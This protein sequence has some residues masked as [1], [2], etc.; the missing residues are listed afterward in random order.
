MCLYKSSGGGILESLLDSRFNGIPD[1]EFVEIFGKTVKINQVKWI[2]FILW[3]Y[4]D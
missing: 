2:W 3:N 1:E 4:A